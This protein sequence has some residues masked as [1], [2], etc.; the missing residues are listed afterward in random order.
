MLNLALML[1]SIYPGDFKVNFPMKM[2][3]Q[4]R[5]LPFTLLLLWVVFSLIACGQPQAVSP[6]P[7][8]TKTATA[9]APKIKSASRVI[10]LTSL[11]ADI[12]YRL[13]QTKLVGIAGSQL[14]AKN[15]GF[16]A[17]P[18]MSEGRTP[19]NLEKIVGA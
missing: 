4:S 8:A 3:S 15:P 2:L 7:A 1:V 17:L 6:S 9:S 12:L 14:L 13:D 16:A 11:S 10:A 5:T 19:P 18:R